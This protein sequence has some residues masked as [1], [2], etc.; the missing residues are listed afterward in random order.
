M[1]TTSRIG[2][3]ENLPNGSTYDLLL[4]RIPDGYPVGQ[5]AF[6]LE[7]TPRSITGIQ[8]VAQLFMKVLFTQKGTD[9]INF[10]LGT[11]FPELAIGA[12]RTSNDASF[13]ADVTVCLKDAESQTRNILSGITKDTDSQLDKIIIDGL[14]VDTES[15]SMYIRIV[16]VAGETASIAIPFPE[17]SLKLANA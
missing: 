10:T 4:V 17:L 3:A 6:E 7:D 12:N 2:I 9:V 13:L 5:V 14:N 16:T 11:N 1:A 15:L 8:K